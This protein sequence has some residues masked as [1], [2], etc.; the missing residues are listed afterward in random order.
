MK[1]INFLIM[2]AAMGLLATTIPTKVA[3][4]VVTA[5]QVYNA[6]TAYANAK[7]NDP[8]KQQ[9]FNTYATLARANPHAAKKANQMRVADAAK[10][11][12]TDIANAKAN[13]ANTLQDLNVAKEIYAYQSEQSKMN[14][15]N[16]APFW[17]KE[18]VT[19]QAAYDQAVSELNALLH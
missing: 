18:I 13:V 4:V 2:M 10:K 11:K 7:S 6:L 15:K 14:K 12:A 5:E 3:A 16:T 1:K 9:L 19:R 17:Q 8:H